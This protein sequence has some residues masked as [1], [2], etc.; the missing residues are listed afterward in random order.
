LAEL[1]NEVIR[2]VGMLE[3][4]ILISLL[5]QLAKLYLAAAGSE[6][7]SGWTDWGHE[8][9]CVG[10][11]AL[12]LLSIPATHTSNDCVVKSAYS[13]RMQFNVKIK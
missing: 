9:S 6:R 8:K 11:A 12:D 10:E 4:G 7:Q 2:R 1:H 13:K 3:E 5:N